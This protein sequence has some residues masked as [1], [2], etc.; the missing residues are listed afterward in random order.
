[1]Q[2]ESKWKL[3]KICNQIKQN[4]NQKKLEKCSMLFFAST[5]SR[6]PS[7]FCSCWKKTSP[8]VDLGLFHCG[9]RWK[10]WH[11]HCWK[12]AVTCC[13]VMNCLGAEIY[14][15]IGLAASWNSWGE[16]MRNYELP[17]TSLIRPYTVRPLIRPDMAH[18]CISAWG[19]FLKPLNLA[20]FLLIKA[21]SASCL[22]TV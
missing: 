4:S 9:F 21:W 2:K 7:Q 20:L 18:S 16:G 3:V 22:N 6:Q 10:H 13:V 11:L 12:S 1:M 17:T 15:Y 14:R 8:G 5:N 19:Q